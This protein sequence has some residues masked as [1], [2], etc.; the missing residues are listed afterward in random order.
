MQEDIKF[1]LGVKHSAFNWKMRHA[2]EKL[3][4]TQKDLGQM[5][6]VNQATITEIE[7]FKR[8]PEEGLA[9][10]ICEALNQDVEK[11]F[12]DYMSEFIIKKSTFSTEHIIT[13]QLLPSIVDTL[14]L[15]DGLEPVEEKI[16][17]EILKKKV[18]SLLENLTDREAK[19]IKMRFGLEED[20][21]VEDFNGI[22]NLKTPPNGST[23]EEVGEKFGVSM[24][25]IRQIEAKA[26]RKMRGP[27][28]TNKL[29][30]F[31][32]DRCGHRFELKKGYGGYKYYECKLC[33]R[34]KN[35]TN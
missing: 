4:L 22:K 21:K 8:F 34:T 25:R 20:F 18:R 11:V 35:A 15:P 14:A 32:P 2:R 24:E 30:E 31:I 13:E 17:Q 28:K 5:I 16:D 26:L 10:K 23:Y 6:G 12:P 29:D 7:T 9:F 1:S 19:I 33:G 3:G 27:S